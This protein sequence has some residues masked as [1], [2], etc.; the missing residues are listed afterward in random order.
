[1]RP[2]LLCGSAL[3][4]SACALVAELDE[5]RRGG[6]TGGLGGAGGEGGLGGALGGGGASCATGPIFTEVRLRGPE[7]G[8][9]ELVEIKNP[10]DLPIDLGTL[11]VAGT[12][13]PGGDFATKWTGVP[14]M[15][16][17]PGARIVVVGASAARPSPFGQLESMGDDQVVV[18]RLADGPVGGS[19]VDSVSICCDRCDEYPPESLAYEFCGEAAPENSFQRLV[20]CAGEPFLLAPSTPNEPLSP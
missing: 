17:A 18:L 9:D 13:V 12:P 16:L 11:S 7:G 15:M 1:M 20:E 10:T 3:L 8:A 4:L 14:G 6:D 2:E 19:V 5:F